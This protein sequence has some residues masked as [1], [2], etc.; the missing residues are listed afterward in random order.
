[1]VRS[2][3]P[4]PALIWILLILLLG[5]VTFGMGIVDA[6]THSFQEWITLFVFLIV[7]LLADLFRVH[8]AAFSIAITVSTV[9][10]FGS[11]LVLGE[12]AAVLALGTLVA[13][14]ILRKS[15]TKAFFNAATYSI[16]AWCS[17]MVWHILRLDTAT[18]LSS[19]FSSPRIVL[20]WLVAGIVLVLINAIAVIMVVSL[21]EGSN[22][23]HVARSSL[24]GIIIQFMTL[25]AMGVL[26]AVLYE[27]QPLSL[28]LIILP[29]IVLY[30]SLRSVEHMR[31][32]TILTI[33]RL[34][35]LLD[36]KDPSTYEHSI[37]VAEYVRLICEEMTLPAD[38]TESV[39]LAARV[40]DLGKIVVP[41]QILFKAGP[42]A[43]REW[44]V[45]RKHAA[46]GAEVLEPMGSYSEALLYIRHHHERWDGH[47]YPDGLAAEDI[48]LGARVIAVADTYD[49]MVSE[50]NYR[51]GLQ[52]SIVLAEIRKQMGTQFDPTVAEVFLSIMQRSTE[53]LKESNS[54]ALP[55]TG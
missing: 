9:V 34:S 30:Y 23:A 26:F 52:Q 41:D 24:R 4:Q 21:T 7:V 37:R 6:S 3:S 22:P 45:M 54:S 33:Q 28:I 20:A 32:Q 43:E 29:L 12:A 35:D 5:I 53:T 16:M 8:M 46:Q 10:V 38:F 44:V 47:G 14:L 1:M 15:L 42:L 17:A 51:D 48:P 50:R 18:S 55:S 2:R 49:A 39:V 27:V 31:E 19:F 13:D 36:R 40:H 25:P 11:A